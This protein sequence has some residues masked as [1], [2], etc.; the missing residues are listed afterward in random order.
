[1]ERFANPAGSPLT[2]CLA[3]MFVLL[4]DAGITRTR[5]LWGPS[6]FE[7]TG[8]PNRYVFAQTYRVARALYDSRPSSSQR[9]ILLGNSRVLLIAPASGVSRE[10]AR[11]SGLKDVSVVK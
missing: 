4:I 10:L 3:L 5:L 9:V 7:R 1:M 2:W 6:E 11:A 8:D